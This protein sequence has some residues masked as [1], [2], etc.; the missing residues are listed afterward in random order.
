MSNFAQKA[1]LQARLPLA[2]FRRFRGKINIQRPRQPH[3]ER[4]RVVAVTNP[5]YPAPPTNQN[6]FKE[7]EHKLKTKIHN[8]YNDIIAREVRNWFEQSKM[9]AIFH[10]NSIT[11]DDL[12]KVR[13]A[14]HRENMQLK[15]YGLAVIKNALENTKFEAVLS[16]FC[17]HH[18]IVF[19]SEAKVARLLRITKRTPQ[20]I[21]IGGIVENTLLSKN[22]FTNFASMP[23]LPVAQAQ[24]VSVLNSAAG[25]IVNNLE[26]HQKSL[27][28]M[29]DAHAKREDGTGDSSTQS[30]SSG[31]NT[32][33]K[34]D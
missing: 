30:G 1:L 22:E 11:S 17:S 4:A 10:E 26:S 32:D 15:S 12:F 13:V 19:S 25:Q 33:A 14:L 8:P 27:V 23:S 6:C 5:I 28:N 3:Y 7:S 24:L 2:E 16:L 29:L 31:D 21:L 18:S 9:V 34:K 20:L